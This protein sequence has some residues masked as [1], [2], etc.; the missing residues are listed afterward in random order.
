MSIVAG[1]FQEF[2]LVRELSA[3]IL[4]VILMAGIKGSIGKLKGYHL[5]LLA[6]LVGFVGVVA[7]AIDSGGIVW[8][9]IFRFLVGALFIGVLT[10]TM[11]LGHWY[12]IQPGLARA[13]LKELLKW[14]GGLCLFELLVWLLPFGRMSTGMISVLNQS[15]DDGHEGLL[16]W[17]WITA[18][19][20]TIILIFISDRALREKGYQAVMATTGLAYLSLLTGFVEDIMARLALGGF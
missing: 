8:L 7:G 1:R 19:V 15:V 12:L 20:T 11:L 3:I 14:G 4:I 17:F 2:N 13:P 16:G 5:D 10:D 6:S 18:T 9:Q